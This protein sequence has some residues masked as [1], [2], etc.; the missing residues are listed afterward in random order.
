MADKKKV[1]NVRVEP[2]IYKSAERRA[3]EEDRSLSA[4][5]RYLIMQDCKKAKKADNWRNAEQITSN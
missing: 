2:N 3:A 4:H 1:L 5:I